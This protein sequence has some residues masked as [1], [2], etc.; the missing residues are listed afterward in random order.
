ML[1]AVPTVEP[2]EFGGRGEGEGMEGKEGGREEE[3]G[4]DNDEEYIEYEIS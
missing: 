4:D 2:L 1:P 3:E